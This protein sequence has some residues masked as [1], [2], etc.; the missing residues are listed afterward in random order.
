MIKKLALYAIGAYILGIIFSGITL[1][2]VEFVPYFVAGL[3]LTTPIYGLVRQRTE[4]TKHVDLGLKVMKKGVFSMFKISKKSIT[5]Y[6][7]VAMVVYRAHTDIADMLIESVST[8][9]MTLIATFILWE[10][11]R[12][13]VKKY[14]K[15]QFLSFGEAV[16]GAF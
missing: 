11:T 7:V 15:V 13:V 16:K 1:A 5:V 2:I 6:L 12:F 3:V 8:G 9:V 4:K 14:K 10:C